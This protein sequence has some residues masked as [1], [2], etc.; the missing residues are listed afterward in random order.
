MRAVFA[1]TMP[2]MVGYGAVT[3]LTVVFVRQSLGGGATE[4]GWVATAVGVGNL[5]G[6]FAVARLGSRLPSERLWSVG[7]A[8]MGG[9]YAAAFSSRLLAPALLFLTVGGLGMA[10]WMVGQQTLLQQAVPNRYL[11]RVLGAVTTASG[12]CILLGMGLASSLPTLVGAAPVLVGAGLLQVL[13]A[14]LNASTRDLGHA[15][16]TSSRSRRGAGALGLPTWRSTA[17]GWAARS[18]KWSVR[19][20]VSSSRAVRWWAWVTARRVVRQSHSM[21]LASGS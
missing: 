18:A 20:A 10:G 6:A 3:V 21:R 11:G 8:V 16:R 9:A 14:L 7:L 1:V 2:V 19:S 15:A 13:A 4:F 17:S 12:L 5:A